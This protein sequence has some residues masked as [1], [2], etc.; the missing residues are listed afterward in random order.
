M[1][2]GGPASVSNRF[3]GIPSGRC[4]SLPSQGRPKD[5]PVAAST[6]ARQWG[7]EEAKH[8]TVAAK[9][10]GGGQLSPT[11]LADV[12]DTILDKA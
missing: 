1:P 9:P 8:M 10:A 4:R 5:V 6:G 7:T 2:E 12:I 11:G 3:C